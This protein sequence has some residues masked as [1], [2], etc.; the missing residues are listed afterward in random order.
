MTYLA[1]L[2]AL[3]LLISSSVLYA[4]TTAGIGSGND[5]VTFDILIFAV[6]VSLFLALEP[7]WLEALN[8]T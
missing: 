8:E 7:A 3:V 5:S 1:G 6:L 4:L 2:A